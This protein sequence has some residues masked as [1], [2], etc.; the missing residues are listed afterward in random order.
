MNLQNFEELAERE[1][2]DIFHDNIMKEKAKIIKY[3]GTSILFNNKKIHSETENKCLFAEELA[4]YYYDAYY[5][6]SS[7]QTDVD[8][9]EYKA[10]K[11]KSLMCVPLKS[12]LS[13]FYKR[14]M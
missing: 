9:A 10:L 3:N 11:W 8:R 6:L 13:C 7:S 2:I 5:T 4:H 1:K 12:I 14:N